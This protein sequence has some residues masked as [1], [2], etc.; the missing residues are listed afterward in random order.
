MGAEG[1]GGAA[2]LL[3]SAVGHRIVDP[4][5]A[6]E[7]E[8][9]RL[10]GVQPPVAYGTRDDIRTPVP[11]TECQAAIAAEHERGPVRLDRRTCPKKRWHGT[12]AS[13]GA[14]RSLRHAATVR[15]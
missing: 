13:V 3:H 1:Y 10:A 2:R 6:V 7:N 12:A 14:G 11:L 15:P 9:D 8:P 4:P 5:G